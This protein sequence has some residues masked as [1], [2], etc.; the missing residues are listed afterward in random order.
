MKTM[1]CTL[2]N[3][4]IPRKAWNQKYCLECCIQN[5]RERSR[6]LYEKE[7]NMRLSLFMI[8]KDFRG[9]VGSKVFISARYPKYVVLK[10]KNGDPIGKVHRFRYNGVEVELYKVIIP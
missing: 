2:C 1:K 7:K 10:T 3:T 8:A 6:M 4:E 5:S 9:K